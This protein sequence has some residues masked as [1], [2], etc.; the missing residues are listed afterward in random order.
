MESTVTNLNVLLYLD[1]LFGMKNFTK[2]IK[3]ENHS[4]S[5]KPWVYDM[6]FKHIYKNL[7]IFHSPNTTKD[8]TQKRTPWFK[9]ISKE[10]SSRHWA[11]DIIIQNAPTC[12]SLLHILVAHVFLV[13]NA[14]AF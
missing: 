2:I 9:N 8:L 12:S 11:S 4:L 1:S 13:F 10:P 7:S 6:K 5:L 14:Y 3:K